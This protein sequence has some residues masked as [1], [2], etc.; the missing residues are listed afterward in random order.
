MDDGVDGIARQQPAHEV[1]VA[2]IAFDELGFVRHRPAEPG[3]QIVEN[4]D[5]LA[6]IEQLEHHMAA[7]EASPTRDQNTH[8]TTLPQPVC[9]SLL[10]IG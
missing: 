8:G 6:G 3:R 10:A 1:M 2:D 9:N 7:D 4:D 5:V